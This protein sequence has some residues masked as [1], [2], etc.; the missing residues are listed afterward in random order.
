MLNTKLKVEIR[1]SPETKVL[2]KQ[3]R[4]LFFDCIFTRINTK[5][6][7]IYSSNYRISAFMPNY[8]YE[9]RTA[10]H[11]KESSLFEQP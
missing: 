11:I 4:E 2:P 6:L 9:E 7:T 3:E 10:R 5:N 8:N 1:G